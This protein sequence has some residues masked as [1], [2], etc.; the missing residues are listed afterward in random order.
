MAKEKRF[1]FIKSGWSM[2]LIIIVLLM[3]IAHLVAFLTLSSYTQNTQTQIN[4]GIIA[5]QII[6]LIEAVEINPKDKRRY[7]VNAIDIPNVS[8]SLNH[9][10]KYKLQVSQVK[11]W[12]VLLKIR[13][14]PKSSRSIEL[15]VKF[16]EHLWLNISAYIYQN[17]WTIQFILFGFELVIILALIF[18]IWSLNR[19][20]KPLKRFVQS[21]ESMGRTLQPSPLTE[22]SGPQ[23][24]REAAK[25]INQMQGRIQQLVQDRTQML[26]AISHDLRTPITRLK[27]RA[28][29]LDDEQLQE[30]IIA[31]LDEMARMINESLAFFRDAQLSLERSDIDVASLVSA[32][33]K[34]DR[35]LGK[36]ISY[37]GS[38]KNLLVK[39]NAL[40]LKRAFSNVINNAIKYGQ[41]AKVTLELND[42]NYLITITDQGPGIPEED[43]SAVFKPFYRGE[44]SRSRSTGGIGLGLAVTES[45][46]LA[47]NG[48]ITIENIEPHGLK[49]TITLPRPQQ[50]LT[51]EQ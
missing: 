40:A 35:E 27:L 9:Y 22:T 3:F 50:E 17:S 51:N 10:P 23:M 33:C 42:E 4:R 49:A 39:G 16:G 28:Q 34:D 30:K 6:T 12:D 21:V 36:P 1:L 11:I 2:V 46:I 45:I 48:K 13:K 31:D 18:M 44:Q 19:Y 15:S 7:I 41:V 29:L 37:E 47:H 8:I 20:N 26:A 24:V 43:L 38:S 5:R 25:A 32:L 14:I